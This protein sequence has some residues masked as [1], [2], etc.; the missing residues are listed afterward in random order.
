MASVDF[1][2]APG[3]GDATVDEVG[4]GTHVASLACATADNGIGI[5]GAGFGCKPARRQDRPGREQR[6][7]LDL[8]GRRQRRRRDQHELRHRRQPARPR[9]SWSQAIEYAL[10]RNVVLVAAAADEATNEQGDPANVLQPTGTGPDIGS[11]TAGCR[12]RRRRPTTSARDS[13][14]AARRSRWPPTAPTAPGARPACS[15]RSRA[16]DRARAGVVRAADARRAAAAPAS[17]ATR[18]TPTCRGRRM[19]SPGGR[20]GRGADARATTR[21]SSAA[22]VVRA[23]QGD[24]A[25][26]R[27][28]GLERGASAG[29]SSTRAPR[30]AAARNLGPPRAAFAAARPRH[31]DRARPQLHAALER[32]A[33]RRPRASSPPASRAYEVWRSDQRRVRAG[34]SP[35]RARHR[36]SVRGRRGAAATRSSRSPSTRPATAR[37]RR[38]APTRACA[39]RSASAGRTPRSRPGGRVRERRSLCLRAARRA[40]PAPPRCRRRSTSTSGSAS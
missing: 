21:T 31:D 2:D 16:G 11:P 23:A 1:D 38:A 37:S 9:R 26:P 22:D 6:R 8:L 19:A 4:H 40:R 36:L 7:A 3:H 24:R 12:S 5:A 15:A 27:R 28:H 25:A 14:A 13:P 34:A 30:C 39:S 32:H 18:A 20:G 35:A 33:T 29:A 10:A 17:R